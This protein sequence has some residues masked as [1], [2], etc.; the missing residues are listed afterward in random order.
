MLQAQASSHFYA[1]ATVPNAGLSFRLGR[2]T[3]GAGALGWLVSV[4]S[5]CLCKKGPW[6][7]PAY[8]QPRPQCI[9]PYHCDPG[10]SPERKSQ[11]LLTL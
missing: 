5:P 9:Q 11:F 1:G 6:Q 3:G 7:V 4:F 8:Q 2:P 10:L